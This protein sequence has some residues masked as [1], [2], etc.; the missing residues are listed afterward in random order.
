MTD[1]ANRETVREF[2]TTIAAQAKVALAGVENPGFLQISRVHPTTDKLVVVGR[3]QFDDV[4]VMV[5]DAVATAEAGHNVYIEGRT[6]SERV[7]GND[8]GKLEDTEW[9]FALVV[10][11]DADKE[12]AWKPN[13][14]VPSLTVETSPGNEQN[15]L[16]CERAIRVNVASKLGDR[17]RAA[18]RTDQDTGNPTQ[19][20]RIAGTPNFP[21]KK[22]LARGRSPI[23]APTS[24]L[25]FD[26]ERLWSLR[27]F[28]KAFPRLKRTTTGNGAGGPTGAQPN[29]SAIPADTMGVIRDGPSAGN[30]DRSQTFWNVMIALKSLGFTVDGIVGLLECYPDGIAKKY[31][32]RLRQQVEHCYDK[33]RV[34]PRPA[35]EPQPPGAALSAAQWLDRELEEP[36]VL[37][38][39]WFTATTR[40]FLFG[41]TGIGKTMFV[42]GAAVAFGGGSDSFLHWKVRRPAKILLIDGEMSRRLMKERLCDEVARVGGDI[43]DGKDAVSRAWLATTNQ[44]WGE[45]CPILASS[46]VL[47]PQRRASLLCF[48]QV[49]AWRK[50]ARQ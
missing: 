17:L 1:P 41:P 36:D 44:L 22:K 34:Q 13:G 46:R 32:G 3:Y 37:L 6:V 28:A 19:P 49:R 12:K 47:S 31:E 18:T 35:P 26:P 14:A 4:E 16:F 45:I 27:D 50:V 21:N 42:T 10:D 43:P 29:E 5:K 20:Y 15:W 8:R 24:I 39:H 40:V 11:N 23:P 25:E 7:R 2:I 9:V 38:G 33:I 48:Q 30:Q